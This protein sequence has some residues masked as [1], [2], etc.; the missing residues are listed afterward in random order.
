MLA[1]PSAR[2]SA[3]VPGC[4]LEWR[5]AS[6][7]KVKR[8]PRRLVPPTLL[9][10]VSHHARPRLTGLETTLVLSD[11]TLVLYCHKARGLP[12]A[13]LVFRCA[14]A[15]VSSDSARSGT[16]LSARSLRGAV[17]PLLVP[18]TMGRY[19]L[20]PGFLWHFLFGKLMGRQLALD[21]RTMPPNLQPAPGL[22]QQYK[23]DIQTFAP[24]F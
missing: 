18:Q 6:A 22:G 5:P 15:C 8:P 23:S 1:L 12:M 14:G 16:M 21:S 24:M 2:A 19:A 13:A 3:A 20:P 7:E 10:P 9:L 4:F 17:T 11:E